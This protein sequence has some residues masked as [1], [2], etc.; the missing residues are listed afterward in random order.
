MYIMAQ[1]NFRIDDN[2]KKKVDHIF[3]DMGLTMSAAITMF[4][5]QVSREYRIP[6]Q[7]KVDPFY[8]DENIKELEQRIESIK[9]GSN[10][11]EE[12]ELL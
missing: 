5:V 8:S 3:N 1:V 2:L 11:L 7:I 4:L 10:S 9:N 12:H 6:F